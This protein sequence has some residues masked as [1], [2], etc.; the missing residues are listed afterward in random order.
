MMPLAFASLGDSMTIKKIQVFLPFFGGAKQRCGQPAGES[1]CTLK[2]EKQEKQV[3]IAPAKNNRIFGALLQI[4]IFA[5]F[6][7]F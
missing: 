3:K 5:V 2:Q 6:G 1:N 7:I 4:L